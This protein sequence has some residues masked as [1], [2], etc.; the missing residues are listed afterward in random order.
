MFEKVMNVQSESR[1]RTISE[2]W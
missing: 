1:N 2:R